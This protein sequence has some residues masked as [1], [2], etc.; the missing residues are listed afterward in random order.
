MPSDNR[1]TCSQAGHAGNTVHMQFG[2]RDIGYAL[3][4]FCA[5]TLLLG[6]VFHFL[7]NL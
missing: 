4:G 6:G 7:G 1:G 2:S 3:T 5:L